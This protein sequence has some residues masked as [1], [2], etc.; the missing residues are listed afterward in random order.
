MNSSATSATGSVSNDSVERPVSSRLL[1]EAIE[2]QI[3]LDSG[4]ASDQDL[5]NWQCWIDAHPDHQHVWQQLRMLD[6]ELKILPRAPTAPLRKL[7]IAP[8]RSGKKVLSGFALLFMF[9]SGG[10]V[11]IDMQ[12][13]L[14]GLLADHATATGEQQQII[15][16]DNTQLVLNSRTVVDIDFTAQQRRIHLRSGE[17]YIRNGHNPDEQRPLLVITDDGSLRALG[18]AFVVQKQSGHTRLDV[19][20]AA[21]MARPKNCDTNATASCASQQQVDAGYGVM[22]A[23]NHISAPQLSASGVDA[24]RNGLLVIDNRSLAEV[25]TELARYSV[26]IITVAPDVAQLRVTAT[27]PITAP[28]KALT[29]LTDA[30][31]IRINRRTGFWLHIEAA[32]TD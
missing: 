12:Q 31:P 3:L 5:D 32:G 22:M 11:A 21:V 6:G 14:T 4:E 26:G 27:L 7:V 23:D 18:T 25:A 29:A 9:I 20:E 15:L 8:R 2:W 17:I 10:L 16:P 28:D 13:P 24:W 1:D 30:L 19:T